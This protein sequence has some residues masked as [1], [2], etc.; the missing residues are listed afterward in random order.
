MEEVTLHYIKEYDTMTEPPGYSQKNA[1][2][3]S[4]YTQ[5]IK[6]DK[7]MDFR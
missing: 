5:E 4:E 7:D 6:E 3:N 1:E 2:T